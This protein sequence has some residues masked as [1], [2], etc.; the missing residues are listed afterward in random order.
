MQPEIVL[1][2]DLPDGANRIDRVGRCRTNGGAYKAGNQAGFFV[3]L[4]LAGEGTGLHGEPVIHFD[5][6]EILRSN[7][8]DHRGFLERRMSL[9]RSITH[10]PTVSALLVCGV[11]AGAFASRQ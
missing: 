3:C 11:A 4:E 5:Q 10:Q 7:P 8:R 2:A 9:G 1:A 6:A